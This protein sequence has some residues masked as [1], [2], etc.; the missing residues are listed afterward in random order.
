VHEPLVSQGGV[1]LGHVQADE[2]WVKLVGRGVWIAMALAVPSRLGLGYARRRVVKVVQRVVRGTAEAITVVLATT[3]GGTA[4]NTAY[5]ERLNATFR[6][7][8]A[9]W[10][11]GDVPLPTRKQC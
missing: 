1:E 2:L 5:I 8:F 3:G 7:A 4:I 6:S 11:A 10:C 9:P